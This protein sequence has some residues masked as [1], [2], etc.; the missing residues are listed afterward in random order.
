VHTRVRPLPGCPALHYSFLASPTFIKQ[1]GTQV[2]EKMEP[3]SEKLGLLPLEAKID[4]PG[5]ILYIIEY[6]RLNRTT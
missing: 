5:D 2:N 1:Y 3:F 6:F 4:S